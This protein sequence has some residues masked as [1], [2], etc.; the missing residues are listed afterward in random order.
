VLLARDQGGYFPPS[1]G[2]SGVALAGVVVTWLVASA[3]TDAGL[4][5]GVFLIGLLALTAWVGLSIA[6]SVDRA[7]SVLEL[8]RG[9][10][11]LAGCTALLIL[12]R[13]A[14][15]EALVASLLAA[16]AGLCAYALSTRLAPTAAGFNADDLISHYRLFNPI[17]YWNGLGLFAVLGI[18]LALALVTEPAARIELRIFASVSLVVLPVTLFFTFSRGAWLALVVGL[19]GSLA[20]SPHRLRLVAEGAAAAV[21][22]AVAVAL[23]W[24]AGPLTH[25][26][27]RLAPASHAGQRLTLELLGVAAASIAIPLLL[28]VLER[29][30]RVGP[31]S[32]RA[33]A[34]GI[35]AVAAAGLAV[36]VARAGGPTSIASRA[37]HAFADPLPPRE[38]TDLTNRLASLNGNGRARMW[39]VAIDSLHGRHWAIGNGAGSFERI[40]DHSKR[41]DEVVKD[42]HGL[43]VETLSELGLIGLVL[44]VAVLSV[45]LVS[46]IRRRAAAFVPALMGG[47][48]AFLA[49]LAVDWDWELSGV[50]LTGLSVGCLLLIAHRQREERPLPAGL[51][52]AGAI[53]GIAAAGFAFVGLTG[54]T[55]LAQAQS[56]NHHHRYEDAVRAATRARRWM[57]WAPAPLQAL[58]TAR[59]EQ[60]NT[61]GAKASFRTAISLD[62]NNWQLWLDLAASVHGK[63]RA[64]AVARARALYPRSPEITEF[65]KEARSEEASHGR[66]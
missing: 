14:V 42:A 49:H 22:P 33:V 29:N 58:G 37:Y 16:I 39:S 51:R 13:R 66:P 31:R 1:W 57:P 55:A 52:A 54:N 61:S 10:V 17:G 36:G 6:W 7:Q 38:Q 15:L 32:R 56:A 23:A 27:A 64:G 3:R 26:G 53:L 60:G 40:W 45:P 19:L 2:W 5:D 41:A 12:G 59:L 50:A 34:L 24:R 46:G 9:L 43:Y 4:A 18:L 47:Y 21:P 20:A 48:L 65:E 63:A 35:V 28:L 30:V 44:L 8:E 62:P 11:L 25:Q